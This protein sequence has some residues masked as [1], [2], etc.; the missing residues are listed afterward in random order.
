MRVI[1]LESRRAREMEELLRRQG[2]E[3]FVAPSVREVGLEANPTAVVFGEALI[4]NEFEAVICLTG[5]GVRQLFTLLKTRFDEAEL[6]GALKRTTTI[7]RG[8]KPSAALR[9]LGVQP[10]AIA[11]DPATYREVLAILASRAERRVAVQEYG[12]PDQRLL[13]GLAEL[14]CHVTQ[15]PVYQWA[16]PEDIKPLQEAVRRIAAGDAEAVLFTSSVQLDHLQ[17][18]AAELGV[19]VLAGLSKLKI[20]SIG[21]TMTEAL[22]AAGLEPAVEPATPKLGFLIHEFA[23]FIK[24]S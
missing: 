19:D 17:Q 3:P 16:L 24:T 21:P 4:R 23:A 14:G 13:S 5:V 10:T 22:R 12:R 8:P 1:A 6:L 20:A 7:A 18:I 15:V 11:P 9:E 2:F